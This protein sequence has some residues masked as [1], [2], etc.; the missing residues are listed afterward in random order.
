MFCFYYICLT[1]YFHDVYD[2]KPIHIHFY[3][4]MFGFK[5]ST[6]NSLVFYELG[7]LLFHILRKLKIV[8][9]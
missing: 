7:K 9:Y 4:K 5:K 8:R 6:C 3:Q 2:T 1:V